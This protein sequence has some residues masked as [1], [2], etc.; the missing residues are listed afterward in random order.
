M[1]DKEMMEWWK[2][3]ATAHND[4]MQTVLKKANQN[5]NLYTLECVMHMYKTALIHGFKHG[6]E[7]AKDEQK[8]T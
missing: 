6:I 1:T 2:N 5:E 3:E 7:K 4:Y 8:N